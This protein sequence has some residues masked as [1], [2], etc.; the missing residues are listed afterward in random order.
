MKPIKWLIKHSTLIIIIGLFTLI[1]GTIF[2]YT[3]PFNV[4]Q[5][6]KITVL[7]KVQAGSLIKYKVNFCRY[8]EQGTETEVRRFIIPKDSELTNPQELDSSPSLETLDN[9]KG[10]RDSETIKLP[11]DIAAPEGEY[12]LLIRAK[13]CLNAF[14]FRR[15]IPVEQYSDYFN[16]GKPSIPNRL[17]IISQ[18]LQDIN[19][20]IQA[21][22]NSE[23]SNSFPVQQIPQTRVQA[24]PAS[25]NELPTQTVNPQETTP[26][27]ASQN[28]L[29][30]NTG[31]LD[32]QLDTPLLNLR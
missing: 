7:N 8:V 9:I 4:A 23:I 12:K 13:Y 10:C 24:S 31:I 16:I 30:L 32:L 6:N 21:N 1:A 14:V 18:Q 5:I 22:P 20:Y 27:A 28:L 26:P 17:S 25:P 11:I 15:C 2:F 29:N 19:A 3:F